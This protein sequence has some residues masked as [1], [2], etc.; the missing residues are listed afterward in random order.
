[1]LYLDSIIYLQ[2]K[3]LAW[4]SEDERQDIRDGLVHITIR[5]PTSS[6]DNQVKVEP[7]ETLSTLPVMPL[8][9]VPTCSPYHAPSPQ[10]AHPRYNTNPPHQNP[11]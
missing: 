5:T 10:H 2:F 6:P 11:T 9:T 4:M 8:P 7:D 3:E 1:M